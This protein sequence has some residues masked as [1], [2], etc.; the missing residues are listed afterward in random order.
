MAHRKLI[1]IL[2]CFQATVVRPDKLSATDKD[3]SVRNNSAI[4]TVFMI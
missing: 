4:I 1:N 2:S 3:D